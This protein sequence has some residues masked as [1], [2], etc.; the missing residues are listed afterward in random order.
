MDL[1]TLIRNK[2][3]MIRKII[4]VISTKRKM[5]TNLTFRIKK[6]QISVISVNSPYK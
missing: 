6:N 2:K 1:V 3:Q 4:L 5:M